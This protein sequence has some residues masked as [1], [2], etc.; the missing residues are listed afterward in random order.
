MNEKKFNNK[1]DEILKRNKNEIVFYRVGKQRLKSNTIFYMLSIILYIVINIIAWKNSDKVLNLM[2]FDDSFRFYLELK[3]VIC[4]LASIIIWI[5]NRGIITLLGIIGR[6]ADAKATEEIFE[7]NGFVT[8][9]SKQPPLV[10]AK[11]KDKT[12]EDSIEYEFYNRGINIE[13]WNFLDLENWLDGYISYLDYSKNTKKN[14]IIRITPTDKYKP[15][16]LTTENNHLIKKLRH[17]LIV[18]ESGSR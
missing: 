14:T 6:P 10:L 3:I 16:I 15:F 4:A 7:E 18:G 13:K 8:E 1:Q 2:N 9:K 11:R 5:I 17:G 12:K